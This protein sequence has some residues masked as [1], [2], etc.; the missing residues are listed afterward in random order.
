MSMALQ[1]LI[2]GE[3]EEESRSLVLR[4]VDVAARM[5]LTL[6]HLLREPGQASAANCSV[7]LPARHR[8]PAHNTGLVADLATPRVRVHHGEEFSFRYEPCFHCHCPLLP[9]RRLDTAGP[10]LI[11]FGRSIENGQW[12]IC[13][14]DGN[15]PGE[16]QAIPAL[17][18]SSQLQRAGTF[19]MKALS[20][21]RTLRPHAS[22]R[23]MGRTVSSQ[24]PLTF[25][26]R[27]GCH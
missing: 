16:R 26:L 25:S 14:R 1:A 3:K 12:W 11:H 27:G 4:S 22:S 21:A 7:K 20:R 8:H 10:A 19:R 6:L 18:K 24:L 17:T 9:R 5:A 13:A 23:T 2:F 15:L